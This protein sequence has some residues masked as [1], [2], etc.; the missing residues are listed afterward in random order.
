M[1]RHLW[2]MRAS[3]QNR[4]CLRALLMRRCATLIT[5][6]TTKILGQMASKT[7]ECI[8]IWTLDL[9]KSRGQFIWSQLRKTTVPLYRV[10]FRTSYHSWRWVTRS[11]WW[12]TWGLWMLTCIRNLPNRLTLWNFC[13]LKA[14]RSLFHRIGKVSKYHLYTSTLSRVCQRLWNLKLDQLTRNFLSMPRRSLTACSHICM[15][16]VMVQLLHH[17]LLLRRPQLRSFVSAEIIKRSTS[18][19]RIGTLLSRI[20]SVL[21]LKSLWIMTHLQILIWLMASISFQSMKKHLW[22]YPYRLHGDKCDRYSCRK[23]FRLVMRIYSRPC[24]RYSKI[25]T[26]PL[27]YLIIFSFVRMVTMNFL[28]VLI[29]H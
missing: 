12:H 5:T 13:G 17:W 21:Y 2:R 24:Q 6:M 1:S 9:L 8:L 16:D 22:S 26:G 15:F 10:H 19:Y 20:H 11:L 27:S 18:L 14:L 3:R 23:E 4:I 7:M 29:W 28:S 25:L